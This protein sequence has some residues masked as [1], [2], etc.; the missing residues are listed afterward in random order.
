MVFVIGTEYNGAKGWIDIPG[1]PSL[2]PVEF[3]KI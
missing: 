2:Q 1:L 3:M